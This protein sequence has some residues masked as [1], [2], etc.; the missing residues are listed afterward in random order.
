MKIR[1]L[2]SIADVTG[3]SYDYGEVA[4]VE[5]RRG[6]QFVKNGHAEAAGADAPLGRIAVELSCPRC[7]QG[8]PMSQP[9][10]PTCYDGLQTGRRAR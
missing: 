7:G 10:C 2:T 8:R 4:E 9:W 6:K 1:F 3:W 5:D